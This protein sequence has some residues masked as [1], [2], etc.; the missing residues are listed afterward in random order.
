MDCAKGISEALEDSEFVYAAIWHNMNDERVRPQRR[1]YTKSGWKTSKSRNG[2]NH[3][4]M[5]GK[6]IQ[7]GDKFQLEPNVYAECPG[8]SGTARNDCRCRCFL[9]YDLLTKDEFVKK[10]GKLLDKSGENGIIK[11]SKLFEIHPDKIN[12]FLL[13][14]GAKHS[15]EFFDVGYSEKDYARLF[16]D[17]EKGFDMS[18]AMSNRVGKE[19]SEDISI[20]MDLGITEI[21]SFRTVWRIKEN[22]LDI[23]PRFITAHR[24]DK[25]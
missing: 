4:K 22:N 21:K 16:N 6:I 18:K 14:P 19:G 23:K 25:I 2:A 13:K 10:D 5:E 11:E 20:F 12:K 15:Q 8:N 17:I 7:V 9:E 24:E 1:Y 3:Q